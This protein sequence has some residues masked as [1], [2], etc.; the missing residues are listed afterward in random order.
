MAYD[1]T[2]RNTGG[3]PIQAVNGDG[4]ALVSV[5]TLTPDVTLSSDTIANRIIR[6]SGAAGGAALTVFFPVTP[7]DAGMWWWIFNESTVATLS[8]AGQTSFPGI[9]PVTT[10]TPLAQA[11]A[12][13]NGAYLWDGTAFKKLFES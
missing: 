8:F 6:I 12:T 4:Y 7:F 1:T 13:R 9:T 3:K 11:A 2:I 5:A 10:S